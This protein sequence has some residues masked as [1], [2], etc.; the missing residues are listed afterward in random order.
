MTCSLVGSPSALNAFWFV[1]LII[2]M[3]I[4]HVSMF[5]EIFSSG[6]DDGSDGLTGPSARRTTRFRVN[7]I[8]TAFA[9]WPYEGL[10]AGLFNIRILNWLRMA[11]ARLEGS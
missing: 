7:W 11:F 4:T 10:M 6:G 3:I 5:D 8:E 1:S 2:E 9:A